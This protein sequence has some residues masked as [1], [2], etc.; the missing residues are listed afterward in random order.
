MVTC[1][2]TETVKRGIEATRL[3]SQLS[4]RVQNLIQQSHLESHEGKVYLRRML[5]SWVLTR[6][7]MVRLLVP[8]FPRFDESMHESVSRNSTSSSIVFAAVVT[9]PSAQLW[10]SS[11][12]DGHLWG[13]SVSAHNS[14]VEAGGLPI[15]PYRHEREPRSSSNVAV[16][17][18]PTLSGL[19]LGM[20]RNAR[21]MAPALGHY[22]SI[23]E[24]WT[25][26]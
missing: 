8:C 26:R 16:Q 15:G 17:S 7:S 23:D 5:S 20:G 12:M 22:G 19:A 2:D 18:I 21:F 6:Y 14:V 1:R 3:I 4:N 9:I 11:R 24:Q 25:R 10:R 13:G